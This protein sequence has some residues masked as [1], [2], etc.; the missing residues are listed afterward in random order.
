MR[1]QRCSVDGMLFGAP[2][3]TT[4]TG[5][6]ANDDNV[7][8]TLSAIVPARAFHPLRALLGNRAGLPSPITEGSGSG[9]G[10]GKRNLTFNAEMFLRVMSICH[11]VVV[12]QEH[13]AVQQGGEGEEG[14][15]G[16][17]EPQELPTSHSNSI[18]NGNGAIEES[19]EHKKSNN[20][21]N[22]NTI[23]EEDGAPYGQSYQAESPDEGALVSAASLEYG[24]QLVGRD[25]SGVEVS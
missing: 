7:D 24:F 5:G 15:E 16:T 10:S 4:S 22:T 12:E 14:E 17:T 2:V 21:N 20:T 11:T 8:T 13:E 1:Y 3:V 18:G 19:V 9:E 23:N 6:R 25:S